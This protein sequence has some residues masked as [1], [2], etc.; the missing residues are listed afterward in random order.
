MNVRLALAALFLST[1]CFAAETNAYRVS[2]EDSAGAWTSLSSYHGKV[3]LIDTVG[4]T[5]GWGDRAQPQLLEL[6]K[7]MHPRG[8]EIVTVIVEG[9]TTPQQ[10]DAYAKRNKIPWKVLRTDEVSFSSLVTGSDP[11]PTN[12]IVSKSGV[13]RKVGLNRSASN[14]TRLR[15][16]LEEALLEPDVTTPAPSIEMP[17]RTWTSLDGKTFE[18]SS[19]EGRPAVVVFFRESTCHWPSAISEE[20]IAEWTKADVRVIGVDVAGDKDGKSLRACTAS[21]SFSFP[22]FRS[23]TRQETQAWVGK[24][25]P[26]G[27]AFVDADGRVQAF[28]NRTP[29]REGELEDRAF[30]RV[31]DRI[32]TPAP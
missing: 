24:N 13:L 4:A 18:S 8:L 25:V 29:T 10:M 31:V 6:Y 20:R 14:A 1:P 15:R 27:V 16:E 30:P 2:L 11:Y 5:C 32:A 3:L 28:S 17:S 7:E 26:F 19:L 22:V 9:D 23:T 21:R 12:F